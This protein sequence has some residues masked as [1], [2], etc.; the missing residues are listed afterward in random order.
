V[1]YR[2]LRPVFLGS[3]YHLW[4]LEDARGNRLKEPILREALTFDSEEEARGYLRC[5]RE[6]FKP[7]VYDR[8]GVATP[9]GGEG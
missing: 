6:R 1:S 5:L 7:L 9:S 4:L 3:P 8:H 2:D